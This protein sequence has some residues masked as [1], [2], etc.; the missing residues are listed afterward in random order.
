MTKK[1]WMLLPLLLLAAC[2]APPADDRR[3]VAEPEGRAETRGIR[4]T[5]AIGYGGSG[6]ADKVDAALDANDERKQALDEAIDS[7][8]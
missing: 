8:N 7:Q 2:G 5:D 4:D 6:V 1:F 3:P